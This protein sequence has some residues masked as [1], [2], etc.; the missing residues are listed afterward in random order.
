MKRQANVTPAIATGDPTE[1]AYVVGIGSSAGGL[2]ALRLLIR[3]LPRTGNYYCLV[4][5]H[6]SPTHRS[7]M[8][9]LLARDAPDL[10]FEDAVS[11]I[12]PQPRTIYI[13][14]PNHD[15]ILQD[16]RLR[17]TVPQHEIGPKPSVDH[18]F[19]SLA[20]SVGSRAIG[21][22]LSG[23]GSDGSHGVRALRAHGGITI[24][25]KPTSAKYD[26]MPNAAIQGGNVDL[27]MLPE[28]IGPYLSRVMNDGVRPVLEPLGKRGPLEQILAMVNTKHQVNF[29]HYKDNT[30]KRQLARRMTTLQIK[31]PEDYLAHLRRTPA[32]VDRLY[33]SF[34]ISV[35]SFFRDPE[36]W[37]GMRKILAR[38]LKA[39][40]PGTPFRA[41][42]AGCATGEEAYTLAMVLSELA[43]ELDTARPI[44][45]FA[46]DIDDQALDTAR[47][48][49]YPEVNVN[50]Q[51]PSALREKYFIQTGRSYRVTK[52]LRDLVVFA[53]HNLAN[54]PPFVSLELIICR[55]VFIYFIPTLQAHLHQMF[56]HA[57][58]SGGILLIGPSESIVD[59]R[60]FE[61]LTAQRGVYKRIGGRRPGER[62]LTTSPITPSPRPTLLATNRT[63][64]LST[65][66]LARQEIL[67]NHVPIC[68]LID[69]RLRCLHFFGRTEKLLSI[70]EGLA[71]L[72]LIALLPDDV[73]VPVRA[74]LNRAMKE[75][76]AQSGVIRR[77]IES[78]AGQVMRCSV[79]QLPGSQSPTTSY[80]I[81]FE[82]L[83][84][85]R[86]GR[87]DPSTLSL[88][89][90][91]R[92]ATAAMEEELNETRENLQTVVE[93]V[94]T[95]N[96]ELQALNEELQANAEELQA[97]NEELQTTNEELQSTNE[98]LQTVNEELQVR[99]SELAST[100]SY[101][102]NLQAATDLPLI[103]VDRE[104]RITRF[105]APSAR[106]F[107]ILPTDIGRPL[108]TLK[109]IVDIAHLE[110]SVNAVMSN[111]TAYSEQLADENTTWLMRIN[112]YFDGNHTVSGAVLNF[113]DVTALA[114][115]KQEVA[116]RNAAL[117]AASAHA[118]VVVDI[119]KAGQPIIHATREFCELMG[120]S[121]AEVL[122]RNCRFLQGPDTDPAAVKAIRTA[123]ERGDTLKIEILNYRKDGSSFWNELRLAPVLM[124]NRKISQYVG[125]QRD[126][127][128]SKRNEQSTARRANYDS[129]TGLTNRT[130]LINRL[131]RVIEA[132][133]KHGERCYVLFID[134]DGFKEINDSLGHTAGDEL[135]VM[136]ANRLQQC[137]RENDTVA[138]FGGDEFVIVLASHPA[139]DAAIRVAE[140]VLAS[141]REPYR[142]KQGVHR[143]SASIGIAT[144]PQDGPDSQALIQ[145]ADT[146]MYRAKDNGRN[147]FA[148]FQ[149]A[150]NAEAVSRSSIKQAIFEGL[151]QHQFDIH[152]Q[153]VID[154]A[155]GQIVS[156]EALLRW[157]HPVNGLTLPGSFINIA[158][159]TGQIL[160]LGT[161]VLEQTVKQLHNWR[162]QIDES[163][164]VS[165]NISA[166]QLHDPAFQ[167]TIEGLPEKLLGMMDFEITEST[168]LGRHR[169]VMESLALIRRKGGRISL[170]DF[171]TGYSSLQFL[172]SFPI[173]ALKIDQSFIRTDLSDERNAALVDSI[174]A[175]SRSI[176]AEVI[177]EGVETTEQLNF[178][179]AR[180]CQRAQGFIFSQA[181]PADRFEAL[182]QEARSKAARPAANREPPMH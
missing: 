95:S 124:P 51:V 147:G 113:T 91:I 80:L 175:L 97:S 56:Q 26:G 39:L 69:E 28:E 75:D 102:E 49:A 90:E 88:N 1:N 32:E 60:S 37:K 85:D 72:D 100:N 161:W 171:G 136:A 123:I 120:Y 128:D 86:S 137:V 150:M 71:N 149:T 168:F 155:S 122:G 140:Q 138:R 42:I 98:E 6:V 181:L 172:L 7:M 156:A 67:K 119:A 87:T 57:L 173:D 146:A 15:L 157:H 12:E 121:R 21:I 132:A 74:L 179:R 81:V 112:P 153:P 55:N 103:V 139:L 107:E 30:I 18:L 36:V 125:L 64:V 63:D 66:D 27:V 154:V 73:R 53:R 59:S 96:E 77:S 29:A 166:R 76:A 3:N 142:L 20:E 167:E 117:Q 110:D 133:E 177:A 68:I 46:T 62:V 25:Q 54:D 47:H 65:A 141:M 164:R 127:T 158:E 165:V 8:A 148:F 111:L 180:G 82:F 52:T 19:L 170:D 50:T 58:N 31:T 143:L 182:Y 94:E 162:D 152:Y 78:A 16:G 17:L 126:I 92:L 2:E 176:G 41:W 14:P 106:I 44:K 93:E 4:A 11:G 22:I 144:Y 23:T 169:V 145:H 79:Q 109:T 159:E 108:T 83:E 34:L 104:L 45:I 118:M 13:T 151:E 163:F 135:L 129:L 38:R 89:D 101:L 114:D 24:A 43:H 10:H 48:G 35:T 99:T 116:V 174:F 5:Q 115:A 178:I 84:T 160:P 134:L 130:L 70:T 131:D 9:E 61:P 33:Q 105:S 40:P